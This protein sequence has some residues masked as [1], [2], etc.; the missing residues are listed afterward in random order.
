M[1]GTCCVSS[2]GSANSVHITFNAVGA[3]GEVVVHHDFDVLQHYYSNRKKIVS[4]TCTVW[5]MHHGGRECVCVCVCVCV[6]E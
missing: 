4:S 1:S 2:S 3:H 6:C 5:Y